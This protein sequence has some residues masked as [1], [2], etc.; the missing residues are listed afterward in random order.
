MVE[1]ARLIRWCPVII[2]TATIAAA[3]CGSQPFDLA[4]VSGRVT[5][6]GQPV[7]DAKVLLLPANRKQP[8]AGP[9][10]VGVT[11][12]DGQYVMQTTGTSPRQGAVVGLHRVIISTL[13]TKP[14][15]NDP[16]GE[17]EIVIRKE[18]IP[19]PYSDPRKT[20]LVLEVPS[21][22]RADANFEI[23]TRQAGR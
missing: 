3:G 13:D 23:Q 10:S 4:P 2:L 6:D 19:P 8:V 22:G 5:L 18:T 21:T 16:G 7:A 17:S 11:D 1:R 20:P 9:A 14:D 12:Q 15:P